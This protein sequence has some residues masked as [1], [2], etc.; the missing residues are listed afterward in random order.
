M[1]SGGDEPSYKVESRLAPIPLSRFLDFL[2]FHVS[3]DRSFS[4]NTSTREAKKSKK[5]SLVEWDCLQDGEWLQ[6][7]LAFANKK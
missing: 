6:E 2:V 7:I 5:P 3:W 1:E 4:S